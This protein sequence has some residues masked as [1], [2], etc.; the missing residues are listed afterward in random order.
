MKLFNSLKSSRFSKITSIRLFS[1]RADFNREFIKNLAKTSSQAIIEPEIEDEPVETETTAMVTEKNTQLVYSEPVTFEPSV[2]NVIKTKYGSLLIPDA[3]MSRF[4]GK[5]SNIYYITSQTKLN[6]LKSIYKRDRNAVVLF[7][8]ANDFGSSRFLFEGV[9]KKIYNHYFPKLEVEGF[10]I[11]NMSPK[12]A[13]VIYNDVVRKTMDFRSFADRMMVIIDTEMNIRSD[14]VKPDVGKQL[15][16][17]I[18]NNQPG[19]TK[20]GFQSYDFLLPMS[21]VLKMHSVKNMENQGLQFDFLFN[22]VDTG[23]ADPKKEHFNDKI[24]KNKYKLDEEKAYNNDI[25]EEPTSKPSDNLVSK[26]RLQTLVGVWPPTNKALYKFVFN[27]MVKNAKFIEHKSKILDIGSGTGILSILIDKAASPKQCTYYCLDKNPEALR[28]TMVNLELNGM[29]CKTELVDVTTSSDF[30]SQVGHFDMIVCNPPWLTA[31]PIGDLDSG[32]YDYKE[33]TIKA[34]F[35][36]VKQRLDPKKG[37]FWLIYSEI[38][39]ILGL[40][41][42]DRI[43]QLCKEYGL[44]VRRVNQVQSEYYDKVVKTKLDALKRSSSYIVYEISHV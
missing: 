37:T 5:L 10:S 15:E 2:D 22:E 16:D 42:K 40:Q 25:E 14:G 18:S 6:Y 35:A 12:D 24:F 23:H 4:K 21:K 3:Y 26:H 20:I 39:E 1:N 7:V 41:P 38:S 44:I 11:K 13:G 8:P 32:N 29:R 36:I 9:S 31:K 43:P 30:F 28:N 33:A 27:L 19:G 17:W 34:V